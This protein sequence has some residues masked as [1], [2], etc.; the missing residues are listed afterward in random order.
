MKLIEV[1]MVE[2]FGT[3]WAFGINFFRL[4]YRAGLAYNSYNFSIGC[5]RRAILITFKRPLR[6]E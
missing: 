4:D 2:T 6:L 5:G 1:T 3:T